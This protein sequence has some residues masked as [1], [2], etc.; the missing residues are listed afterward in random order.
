MEDVVVLLRS[1]SEEVTE[2]ISDKGSVD[3]ILSMIE[4]IG[5]MYKEWIEAQPEALTA[6][7]AAPVDGVIL[8]KG[9][10]YLTLGFIESYGMHAK[11]GD[12]NGMLNSYLLIAKSFGLSIDEITA[13]IKRYHPDWDLSLADWAIFDEVKRDE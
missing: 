9:A 3:K 13:V 4:A 8:N 12:K 5:N 1:L 6:A 7:A 10:A 11:N 2:N